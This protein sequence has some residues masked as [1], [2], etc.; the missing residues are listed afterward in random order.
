MKADFR[1]NT[2]L[3]LIAHGSPHHDLP[4][5]SAQAVAQTELFSTLRS[6]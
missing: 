3:D 6:K 5:V 2:K 4:V 1:N